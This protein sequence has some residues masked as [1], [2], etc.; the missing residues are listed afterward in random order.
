[1]RFN[2]NEA[3][4]DASRHVHTLRPP[5]TKHQ[6]MLLLS[7]LSSFTAVGQSCIQFHPC[8]CLAGPSTAL[9]VSRN[10][11][12]DETQNSLQPSEPPESDALVV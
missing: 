1:M 6:A 7:Q 4:A 12:H 8:G 10:K 5:E 11:H 2:G 3:D 9:Q